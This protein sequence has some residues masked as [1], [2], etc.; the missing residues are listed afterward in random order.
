MKTFWQITKATAKEMVRDRMAMFWFLAFP[1]IFILLFGLIF[2]GDGGGPTFDVGL[3]IEDQGG[4]GQALDTA[5]KSVPAF[6]LHRGE[7]NGELAAL[8]K[9]DRVL[10]VVMPAPGSAAEP[11]QSDQA[12][13]PAGTLEIPLYYDAGRQMANQ[14]LIPVINEVLAGLERQVTGRPQLFAV[15]AQAVQA[16]R[17]RDIDY[18]LPGILAMALMQLGLFG[19]LRLVSLRERKILKNLGA[20]PLNRSAMLGSEVFVRL[21]MSLIQAVLVI[22]IGFAV[23]DVKI[24]GNWAAVL[25]LVL[26]GAATFVS[27]GYMLVS[28]ARTEE[29]GGGLIQMVQF[30][31]MFLS[32]IFFPVDVMPGFLQS[33]VRIFPL[34][35]LGDAMR[36]MMVGM[37]PLYSLATDLAVLAAWLGLSLLLAVRL[38]RWE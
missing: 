24:T 15:K 18:V 16:K 23:F 22:V 36:Q 26:L 32:G 38:W 19:S 27:L 28:F 17:L 30:P 13:S 5:L 2:S 31:M 1:V 33:I 11:V 34:T 9:G 3:V 7:L 4:L 37:A 14:V 35:Y 25:G 20:T 21:V 29:S 10:V 8:K 12:T 6:R